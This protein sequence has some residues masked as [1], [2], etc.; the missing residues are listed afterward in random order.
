MY[1]FLYYLYFNYNKCK[2]HKSPV[3]WQTGVCPLE[4]KVLN[5]AAA[6][7]WRAVVVS[8]CLTGR[9]RGWRTQPGGRWWS[10]NFAACDNCLE[11]LDVNPSAHAALQPNSMRRRGGGG[12]GDGGSSSRVPGASSAAGSRLDARWV[13]AA[14]VL[15]FTWGFYLAQD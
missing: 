3:F 8:Q 15:E 9:Q 12:E 4:A 7:I 10:L 5:K 13:R 14:L 1:W 2:Y 6:H 11:N